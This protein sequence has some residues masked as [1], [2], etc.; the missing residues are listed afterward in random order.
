MIG[1]DKD[2]NDHKGKQ[3]NE[4]DDEEHVK[5]TVHTGNRL[6]ILVEELMLGAD[7]NALTLAT[8]ELQ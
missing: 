8:Q 4:E 2:T 1:Q 7:D 6:K 3:K 5:S